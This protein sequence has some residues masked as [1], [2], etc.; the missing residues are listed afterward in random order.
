ML[1]NSLSRDDNTPFR[2]N[3]THDKDPDSSDNV[4]FR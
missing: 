1:V 2:L 3:H 4:Y